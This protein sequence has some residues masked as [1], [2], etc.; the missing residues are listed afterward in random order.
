MEKNM[1]GVDRAVRI[2]VGLVLLAWFLVGAGVA[3][4]WA[5]IGAVML[6]TGLIGWCPAYLPFGF[7]T[8]KRQ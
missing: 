7:K 8:C 2:V 5:L 1:G 6:G 4:W 3:W